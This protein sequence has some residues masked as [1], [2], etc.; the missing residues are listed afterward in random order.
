[1][2]GTVVSALVKFFGREILLPS[3]PFVLSLV[4]DRPVYPLFVVRTGRQKY[5]IIARE[6]VVCDRAG[7]SR[8]EAVYA[9]MQKWARVL[10]EIV[11]HYWPQWFAFT[12][13]C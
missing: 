9:A 5:K 3:G 4:S 7:G 11:R 10:E 2:I 1:M 13:L 12:P 6:P 8:D